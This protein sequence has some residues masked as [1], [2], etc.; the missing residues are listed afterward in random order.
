MIPWRHWLP[1]L[2][3]LLLVGGY[4]LVSAQD[5]IDGTQQEYRIRVQMLYLPSG[6][7]VKRLSLGYRG[8]AACLYW[9]RAVQHYGRENVD[10]RRYRLLYPLLDITT[11]LDPDLMLAYHFGALFLA[12]DPPLGPGRPDQ[13][14]ALLRKGIAAHPEHWRFWYDLGFVYYRALE[15]YQR[16][17][18]AFATGADIPGA[19]SWMRVMSVKVAAEGASRDK[20][21]FLWRELYNA[22]DDPTIRQSA[23]YHLYGL[24]VDDDIEFLQPLLAEFERRRGRPARTFMELVALGL[25]RELP[26]DPLGYP[27]RLSDDGRVLLHLESRIGTSKLGTWH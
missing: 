25:L 1:V 20:A 4:A 18:E 19:E 15:D 13:A 9:T 8:L 23:L 3:L 16:A 11:T 2:F 26:R 17:S 14:I 6:E 22:T 10:Q 7:W 21:R 5:H 12:E 27:Y 24:Q